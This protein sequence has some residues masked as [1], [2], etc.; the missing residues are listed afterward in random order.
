MAYG[1]M[2][3]SDHA[4]NAASIVEGLLTSVPDVIALTR[5]RRLRYGCYLS[6]IR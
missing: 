2:T 1:A 6:R 3:N 4:S 5:R